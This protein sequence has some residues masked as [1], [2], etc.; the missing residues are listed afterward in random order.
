[1]LR[2]QPFSVNSLEGAVNC[3]KLSIHHSYCTPCRF[4][5]ISGLSSRVSLLSYFLRY[6]DDT[7]VSLSRSHPG[8]R[9]QINL[10]TIP[11]SLI[12]SQ[13]KFQLGKRCDESIR[14]PYWRPSTRELNVA[15]ATLQYSFRPS[16]TFSPHERPIRRHLSFH[17]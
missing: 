10:E 16:F 3:I 11:G 9:Y 8:R 2:H 4:I 6:L 5:L 12:L 14:S 17:T 1:M 7:L 13:L 15:W